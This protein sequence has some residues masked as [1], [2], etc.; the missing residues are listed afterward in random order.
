MKSITIF[1]LGLILITLLS[2]I[3]VS[4]KRKPVEE[5]D[6]LDFTQNAVRIIGDMSF[7]RA[8][9]PEFTDMQILEHYNNKF[10][11]IFQSGMKVFE[12]NPEQVDDFFDIR[13]YKA[14]NN[15]D[16]LIS[17]AVAKNDKAVVIIENLKK[18]LEAI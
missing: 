5:S 12:H 10:R 13:V 7:I 2:R 1:L 6:K 9:H 18:Q 8:N 14:L 4:I 11:N 3:R 16:T 17:E 15:S